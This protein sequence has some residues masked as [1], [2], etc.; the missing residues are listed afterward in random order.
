[1]QRAAR[2]NTATRLGIYTLGTGL[3]LG[4]ACT[5]RMSDD[6]YADTK[7]D[8]GV[9]NTGAT[10]RATYGFRPVFYTVQ[11]GD[12]A[13]RV[14]RDHSMSM[15]ELLE[16]NPEIRQRSGYALKTG[17]R[18]RLDNMELLYP[19]EKEFQ[20]NSCASRNCHVSG[21]RGIVM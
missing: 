6:G 9:L 20:E 10:E 12:C 16:R 11:E 3:L 19:R 5:C 14:A 4:A 2:K 21:P 17:E 15:Q 13:S 1:M 18:V 8:Q 7:P